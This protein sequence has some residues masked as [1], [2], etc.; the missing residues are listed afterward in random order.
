MP[1]VEAAP[2]VPDRTEAPGPRA[3]SPPALRAV[4]A[5]ESSSL[6]RLCGL[7]LLERTLRSL[8]RAGIS[9]VTVVSSRADVLEG[10]RRRH[11]S[12]R[13]LEVKTVAR[14]R[15]QGSAEPPPLSLGELRTVLEE[16]GSLYVPAD[17]LCDVSLLSSLRSAT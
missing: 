14:P 15:A 3:A 16:D 5:A 6:I 7:T 2:L 11:W 10:A 13:S 17:V 1:S 8:A 12:R 9:R 4:V